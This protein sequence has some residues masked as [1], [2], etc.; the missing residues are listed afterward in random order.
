M[1]I[2]YH[3][4]LHARVLSRGGGGVGLVASLRGYKR[5]IDYS[6]SKRVFAAPI[7][8]SSRKNMTEMCSLRIGTS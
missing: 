7:R 2:T 4:L 1:S 3:V 5:V 6:A 8:T